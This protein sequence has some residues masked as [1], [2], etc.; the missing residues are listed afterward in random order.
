M[1]GKGRG[2]AA[3]SF[4]VLLFAFNRHSLPPALLHQELDEVEFH[5]ILL[6]LEGEVVPV[7]LVVR[8]VRVERSDASALGGNDL[9]VAVVEVGFEFGTTFTGS[10][11][12]GLS[13]GLCW[14]RCI[15]SAFF[16]RK[17]ATKW[18]NGCGAR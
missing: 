8:I 14:R 16:P 2:K 3:P 13:E 9:L 11:S 15:V 4:V 18:T 17:R 1:Y 12:T 5:A 10:D 7:E 6:L